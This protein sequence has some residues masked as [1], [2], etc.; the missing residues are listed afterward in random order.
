[1]SGYSAYFAT[2][3]PAVQDEIIERTVVSAG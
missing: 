3:P 1:V 2:L